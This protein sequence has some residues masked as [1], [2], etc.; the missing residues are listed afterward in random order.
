M[1]AHVLNKHG[2]ELGLQW[3][4]TCRSQVTL[5]MYFIE[6][7]IPQSLKLLRLA[8]GDEEEGVHATEFRAAPVKCRLLENKVDEI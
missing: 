5:L 1:Y 7:K 3:H 4:K 8:S 6:I 2:S